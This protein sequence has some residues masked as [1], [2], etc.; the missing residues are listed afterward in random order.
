MSRGR[1][2]DLALAVA[3]AVFTQVEVWTERLHPYWASAP[4]TLVSAAA[5]GWRRRAPLTSTLVVMA[6][7]PAQALLGV[8]MSV[9]IYPLLLIMVALYG[10]AAHADLR[11]ALVGLA[12]PL[13]AVWGTLAVEVSQGKRSNGDVVF[14]TVLTLVPWVIGRAMRGQL[15][16]TR[17]LERDR[18]Q[19]VEEERARIARE[20]HDVIAH[21]V[22]VMVVQA[23]AAEEML[24]LDPERAVEPVRAVQET[25][26]QA[27]VE[28]TRLVGLLRD[29]GEELG[30]APQ[31]GLGD[32]DALLEQVREAGLS[33]ALRVEGTPREVSLGVALSAY[34]VV[35]EALTNALKHAG[36]ARADVVGRWRPDALE[37]EVTDDGAG[38]APTHSGGH[39]LVGMR[40]RIAVFG[41]EF[42]AGPRAGGGFHVRATLPA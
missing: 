21:S 9:P 34:R 26:R 29:H 42:A 30:L 15:D 28:M 14:V 2:L 33:V 13:V 23:G 8:D 17:R 40:E 25:G 4:L 38:T 22:S 41:G 19:A 35:Q 16:E 37:V 18:V 39:G 27:L 24:R 10:V 6:P 11:R 32:L 31:P 7:L 36:E 3:V 1:L 12:V 20:L 5:L